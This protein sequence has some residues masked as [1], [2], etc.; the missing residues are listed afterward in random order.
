MKQFVEGV[1]WQQAILPPEYL[2]DQF[3]DNSSVCETGVAK[4]RP[5]KP[6]LVTLRVGLFSPVA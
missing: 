6:F 5:L 2:E 3:D 4:S 1:D